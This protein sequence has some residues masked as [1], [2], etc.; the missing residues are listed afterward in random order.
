MRAAVEALGRCVYLHLQE[1]TGYGVAAR[2]CID[3]LAVHG[4]GVVPVA[5]VPEP[6]SGLASRPERIPSGP[7]DTVIAHLVPEHFPLVRQLFPDAFLIGH[8]VWETDRPP[9]HWLAL[10]EV[11]D[12]LVVPCRWNE[13][14]FRRAGVATPIA[15]VPHVVADPPPRAEARSSPRGD[16]F[17][18]YT[19][20]DWNCRK[21]V[22]HTLRAFLRAFDQTD[23]VELV[24]K[25]SPY[26]LT[27]VSPEH[28]GDRALGEG[29]TALAVARARRE[30]P[31][32]PAVELITRTLTGEEVDALHERGDCFV[33]LCRSEG[34]GLAS[35]DA[36][37]HANP[38]VITGFGGQLDYL[39]PST[40]LLV[41][42]DVVAVDCPAGRPSYTPD[43]RWAEPDVA[44]G[45]QLLRRVVDDPAGTA[46]RADR[47]RRRVLDRYAPPVIA[48]QFVRAVSEVRG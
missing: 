27:D 12:L 39:D 35:F 7:V 8:T 5:F 32:P 47:L 30:I 31:R 19:I 4:V 2:R 45:A 29:S 10:L 46:E 11:P 26:D 38:I 23:P 42:H 37:A 25:T 3:A 20:A 24:I 28:A 14:T 33:S 22:W 17:V 6:G 21:A 43:Q 16:Q 36:A 1:P 9:A 18:F 41:D 15:V 34:W 13:Q 40:A 48:E 44:H